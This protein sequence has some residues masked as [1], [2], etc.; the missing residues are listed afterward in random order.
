MVMQTAIASRSFAVDKDGSR[1]LDVHIFAP[2]KDG[3][4]YR[5]HYELIESGETIRKGHAFGV[6]GIQAL[7]LAIERTGI[8]VAVSKYGQENRLFWNGQNDD[9]GLPL[10]K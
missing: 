6:D 10:P 1:R 8:D 9:L 5:C 3:N 4:D 2:V 7:L